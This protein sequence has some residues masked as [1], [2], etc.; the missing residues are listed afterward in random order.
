MAT[1]STSSTS[2][3][4]P[5]MSYEAPPYTGELFGAGHDAFVKTY[6]RTRGNVPKRTGLSEKERGKIR[7]ARRGG[8]E[9]NKI[10]R[11]KAAQKRKKNPDDFKKRKVSSTGFRGVTEKSSGRYSANIRADRKRKCLGTFDT[12]KEAARAYDRAILKYN[13]P[14][15]KLNFPPQPNGQTTI[16]EHV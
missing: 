14:I 5:K 3:T 15:A 8:E 16:S 4:S 12:A 1:S 6:G 7:N 11:E 10:R 2:S 9:Y 13:Q